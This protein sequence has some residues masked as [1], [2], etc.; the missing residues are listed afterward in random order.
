MPEVSAVCPCRPGGR[1]SP[2]E[3]GADGDSNVHFDYTTIGHVSVDVMPGGARRAGGSAFY[4]A[5]QAARLGQ[6]SLII[7][8]GVKEDIEDLLA[9]YRSELELQIVPAIETT[10]LQSGA[11]RGSHA[12]RLL[13]WAGRMREGIEV[14][15]S[16]VHLAPIARETPRRWSGSADFIGLTPQGL[17]RAWAGARGEIRPVELLPAL[18][19]Q[20]W[21]AAVISETERES[22]AGLIPAAAPRR[23]PGRGPAAAGGDAG[24]GI[25]SDE[26]ASAVANRGVVAVTAGAGPTSIHMQDGGVVRV[27][28]PAV[29]DFHDDVGAGDVFAAAFFIALREGRTPRA[30]AAFANAAAA[31]RIA[32]AGSDSIGDRTAVEARLAASRETGPTP[33]QP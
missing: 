17:V 29:D 1:P 10:T 8:Q 24:P 2:R 20:R 19:P 30:A 33:H 6:R 16:I 22:C 7:T 11:D 15:S 3:L 14:N 23:T 5:L 18:L 4:S 27:R 31:V 25:A 9:P 21:D 26:T 28:V 13:A 12:Q 32:G